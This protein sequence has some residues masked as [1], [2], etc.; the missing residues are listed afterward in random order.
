MDQIVWF[1]DPKTGIERKGVT[2]IGKDDTSP[3]G[4]MWIKSRNKWH[5]IHPSQIRTWPLYEFRFGN[6]DKFKIRK[7]VIGNSWVIHYFVPEV[8][9]FG[10]VVDTFDEAV[11]WVKG[12]MLQIGLGETNGI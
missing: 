5:F 12:A 2:R 7:A 10:R 9:W 11:A 6:P 4:L 8:G 3:T 1:T